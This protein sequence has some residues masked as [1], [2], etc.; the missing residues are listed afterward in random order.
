MH[1]KDVVETNDQI[2][3]VAAGTGQLDYSFYLSLL[4]R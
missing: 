3:H 4:R 1:A 2:R